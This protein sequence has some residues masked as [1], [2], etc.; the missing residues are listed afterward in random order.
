MT[1]TLPIGVAYLADTD[2]CTSDGGT[3][4]VLT[5]AL[6]DLERYDYDEFEIKTRVD[7]GV[8]RLDADGTIVATAT[9]SVDGARI[10]PNLDN[11]IDECD[12]FVQDL[13]DLSMLKMS[14]PDDVGAR[15]RALHAT[16]S[17]WTTWARR[18]RAAC[19]S[20]TT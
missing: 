7:P 11:N 12:C 2:S 6:G 15:R 1:V 5:C 3:P 20:T 14:K 19:T 13:A 9:A 8:V 4:E 17:T 10:D 18:G 16:R